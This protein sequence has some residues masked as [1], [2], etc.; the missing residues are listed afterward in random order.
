MSAAEKLEGCTL[1]GGWKVIKRLE[2]DPNGT[3]GHF[4]QSYL[5]ERVERNATGQE[6]RTEGFLKAFDFQRAFEGGGDT[7][8]ILQFLT[9][10]YEYERAIL[11]HCRGRRLS[12]VVVAIDHGEYQVEGMSAMEGRVFYLIF[13]MAAGDVRVQM[14]MSKARDALW[15]LKALKDINLGLWQVHRE[16]IAHQDAKPSNVLTY[17]GPSFKIA[18]FGRASRKGVPAPHDH[19]QVAGDMTYSPPEQLYGYSDPDFGARRIGCDMYMLGNLACFL[20]SGVNVTATLL[21]HLAPQHHPQHWGGSY[22][23]VLPY[24]R[25]AFAQVL[26]DLQP[27]ID[28]LVRD[29]ITGLVTELC[30]PDLKLRGHPR[31]IGHHDQYSLQRYDSGLDQAVRKLQIRIR[32]GGRAA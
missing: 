32:A 10:S 24:V 26:A 25:T 9:N 2:R 7:V 19:L 20:F 30:D 21:S 28:P 6:I 5:A 17:A 18:D 29:Y 15:C 13:E 3:G 12:N 23:E 1:Q 8:K 4:S 27:L 14:D 11:E 22:V 16:M 31:G